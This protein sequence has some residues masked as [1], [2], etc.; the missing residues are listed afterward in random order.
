[1]NDMR[2][3]DV[4]T[5]LVV[6]FRP[7]DTIQQAARRMLSNRISGAPVVENGRLVGIVSEAD[8]VAACTSPSKRRA[9]LAAPDPLTF[10]LGGVAPRSDTG[11][12]VSD[13]M[14]K[15]VVTVSP[16]ASLW[17]AASLIE[18]HGVR[19]LPVVDNEGHLVGIVARAD[20]VRSM[21]RD[22]EETPASVARRSWH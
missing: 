2:V 4:M 13:V 19:R 16:E 18:R 10:L 17:E 9:A 21:A 14:R 22:A 5:H 15:E 12:T 11:I 6:T 8:L 1:M 20:L 3:F 7:E